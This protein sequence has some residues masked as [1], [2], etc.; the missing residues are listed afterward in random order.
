MATPWL[1]AG[2]VKGGSAPVRRYAAS[3]PLI[4]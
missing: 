1:R 3:S 2:S 4:G